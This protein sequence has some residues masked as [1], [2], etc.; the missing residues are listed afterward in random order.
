M[1]RFFC[2]LL[3]MLCCARFLGAAIPGRVLLTSSYLSKFRLT[4]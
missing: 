4:G 3:L 1:N 2:A